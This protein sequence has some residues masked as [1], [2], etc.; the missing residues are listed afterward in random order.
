[1]K[2]Y[3]PI[4]VALLIAGPGYAQQRDRGFT[5]PISRYRLPDAV[6]MQKSFTLPE[7]R[8]LQVDQNPTYIINYMWSEN[9]WFATDREVITYVNGSYPK[10]I[11]ASY[12]ASPDTL[13]LRKE[14]MHYN[15]KWILQEVETYT[16]VEGTQEWALYSKDL[17]HTDDKDNP[18]LDAQLWWNEPLSRW[19]TLMG[20]RT[21]FEYNPAGEV[22][23]ETTYTWVDNEWM[24]DWQ[25]VLVY[26]AQGQLTE[27]TE[28][29]WNE[30]ANRFDETERYE[31]AYDDQGRWEEVLMY[32]NE[33]VSTEWVLTG[34]M[35][36]F[37]WVDFE[38]QISLGYT[39]YTYDSF[40]DEWYPSVRYTTE[41][42]AAGELTLML[43]EMYDEEEQEWIPMFRAITQYDDNDNL[44]LLTMEM[45][46][47]DAWAMITGLR[48]LYTY[49]TD[50]TPDEVTLQVYD[51]EESMEWENVSKM[52]FG[53][54]AVPVNVGD[55]MAERVRVYPNPTS[56]RV[57]VEGVFERV[58]V[59]NGVGQVVMERENHSGLMTLDLGELR[60]GVYFAN[61][62]SRD[63]RQVIKLVKN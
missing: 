1:M 4:L 45:Y 59:Y 53:Y 26:D 52:E 3:L 2:K 37:Q 29:Y 33:P 27:N 35:A 36:D 47:G 44:L 31:Y 54:E 42:N 46:A 60:E 20:D 9:E 5:D 39:E 41:F 10:E 13:P 32:E 56:G 43:G 30:D 21:V 6:A 55:V 7:L 22:T 25:N 15:A 11:I 23:K 18:V 28:S 63:I 40:E 17:T 61:I 58:V 50:G 62:I 14:V 12:F 51:G 48:N 34:K 24:P 49:N 38:Q 16:P 8:S 19:D 57:M